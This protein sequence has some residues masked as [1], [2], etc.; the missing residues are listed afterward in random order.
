MLNPASV[1]DLQARWHPNPLDDSG[2]AAV[3]QTRLD[4]AWRA[5]QRE[6]PG[7][8]TRLA[9]G[10]V[11]EE[12]IIDVVSSAALRVLRNPDAHSEGSFSVD[13]YSE[14]W[15]ADPQSTSIDLYFT[16]AEL[17][18]LSASGSAQSAFTI[19]PSGAPCRMW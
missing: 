5:L 7:L 14:G 15:K 1:S 8:V 9:A 16:R 17:R 2:A 6:L 3:A 4:E 12:D 13:D 18:R 11:S 10:A 19:R